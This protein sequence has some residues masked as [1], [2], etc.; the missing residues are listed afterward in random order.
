M[1]LKYFTFRLSIICL[2]Q[3]IYIGAPTSTWYLTGITQ[4]LN[5][6]FICMYICVYKGV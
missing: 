1:I 3:Y 2:K 4:V 5:L 6:L